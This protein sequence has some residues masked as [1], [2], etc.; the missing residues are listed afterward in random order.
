MIH[1]ICRVTGA[2]HLA[3]PNPGQ[4]QSPVCRRRQQ[5]NNPSN[6]SFRIRGIGT[7]VFGQG[8]E[9]S[10]SA[11][12]DGVVFARQAQGFTDLADIERIEVL[13]GPQGTLFGKNATGGVISVVTARPSKQLT[14]RINATI[15]EKGEYHLNGTV[16]S[17][18][19]D[20][21]G[22]RLTGFYNKDDGYI[23]N[24][25]L[26]RKTNGYESWGVR[27]KAEWDIGDLNLLAT[28]SYNKNNAFCCQQVLIRSD[29]P[30]LTSLV[31]PVVPGPRNEQ[32]GSNLDTTSV[33][34]QQLYSLE[35]NYKLG[36]ATVTSITAY[37]RYKFNNNVDVDGLYTPRPIFAGLNG[38][39][40]AYGQFD[41]NGGPIDL[42]QFSQ[43]LRIASSGEHRFNY[44]VG[45][46]Y[47]TLDLD[48]DFIRRIA[49]CPTTV[50]A[51]QG[52]VV[53]AVC[54]SP[55]FR[56][57]RHH[58]QLENEHY[59]AFGQVDYR[60]IGGLKLIGGLRVQHESI[61]VEGYQATTTPFAGDS[62]LAGFP[63]TS[64]RATAKDTAVTGK[65]G[66]QYEFSRNAQIYG[67]YTKG[68]KGQGFGT[69]FT[70]TFN[71][72]PVI[73]PET[74]N[75][76]EF[77]VKGSTADQTLSLS[78]AF[79][80]S[81]YK[82]LQVQANRTDTVTG[83]IL[84]VTTNAGKAQ[85]KGFE[86]EGVVRPDDHFSIGFGAAYTHARFDSDGI[87][88]PVQTQAAAP[89]IGFGG[90]PPINSCF[91]ATS[92]GGVVSGFN[93]NVRG[94]IMP[95][96]PEWRITLSP[97]YER[98]IGRFVG[99]AEVNVA[100][101]SDVNFSLEQDPVLIQDAYTTVDARIGIRPAGTGLSASLW[102]KNLGDQRYY[103]NMG[104]NSTLTTQAVTPN[105][106]TAFL[107][108]GAFR[109]FGATLGY[110][111]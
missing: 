59:A 65:A 79:F 94:G 81:N 10:V 21:L 31:S 97:R 69:E 4:A 66:L 12:L 43:E 98:E 45:G 111:F 75:A 37:Q 22:V 106:L 109:Y 104:H 8:N 105:N 84:F 103:T 67:S 30:D 52:L 23:R 29:N 54:P 38:E 17:P 18:V 15:A 48:R 50:A 25:V 93:Q 100:F 99:Y 24:I 63:Q 83:N 16:S 34:S 47:S 32:V 56:S 60:L 62:F 80:L 20:T 28:A 102:V 87:A 58:A 55:V 49:T 91:R 5:G 46:Y 11:V 13:R 74:V 36:G 39:G 64:G 90:T 72:N 40:A 35:A 73:E 19:T 108:K 57:G 86:I 3:L 85:T 33:T 7:A 101:Q 78:I 107:P 6:S 51:N 1:L 14:G 77:G 82:N 9:P 68:Y 95:N 88:C 2:V 70:Q 53:G 27:G 110:S 44:V 71:N 61:S 76:Y 26:D 92:A 41:V 89:T 42:K 96:T